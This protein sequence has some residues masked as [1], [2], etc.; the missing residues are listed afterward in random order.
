ML[1]MNTR[2]GAARTHRGIKSAFAATAA[3]T[4][5]A[6]CGGGDGDKKASDDFAKSD[7]ADIIAAAK[8]DMAALDSVHLSGEFTSTDSGSVKL[9]LG[10]STA[11]ECSGTIE[12]GGGSAE[13]LSAD[14][15]SWFKPD[16]AFWKA[17]AG[18]QADTIIG[19]VGDKWVVLPPDDTSFTSFCDL[20][21]LLKDITDTDPEEKEFVN[22]G[23]DE[24]DGDPAVKLS[25]DDTD[26]GKITAYVAADDPH[27]VVHMEKTGG[28]DP[29]QATFSDFDEE[30]DIQ[31]P[32]ES[33]TIDLSSLG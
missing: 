7:V 6:G 21:E 17:S 12:V 5:L 18:E 3:V 24:F 10:V 25:R 27:Y 4:L 23:A 30:L 32:A 16:E 26:G 31:A 1:A 9:D 11:G 15:K 29:G 22:D 13:I 2:R 28:D 19:I 20:D 14:G 33:D 8:K